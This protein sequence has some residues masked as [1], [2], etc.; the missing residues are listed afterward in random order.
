[1][2]AHGAEVAEPV[3]VAGR[4][5]DDAFVAGGGLVQAT[6]FD[7]DAAEGERTAR[8]LMAE[9]GVA[10]ADLVAQAYVDLLEAGSGASDSSV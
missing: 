2:V 4:Q 5:R 3:R 9:L 7:E 10:P 6:A 1:M 8:R